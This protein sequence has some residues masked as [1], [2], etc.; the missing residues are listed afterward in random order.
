MLPTRPTAQWIF[1][2]DLAT[3]ISRSPPIM[4]G[5]PERASD[6]GDIFSVRQCRE[7]ERKRKGS[8]M[9]NEKG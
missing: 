4:L 2:P 8:R 6:N 3:A 7:N 1:L 5:D 9:K